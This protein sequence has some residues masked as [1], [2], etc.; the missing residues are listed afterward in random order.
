MSKTK[1]I[2]GKLRKREWGDRCLRIK[3]HKAHACTEGK[4]QPTER[5]KVLVPCFRIALLLPLL[6]KRCMSNISNC[7]GFTYSDFERVCYGNGVVT[8]VT[9]NTCTRVFSEK[10]KWMA[11]KEVYEILDHRIPH[12]E[13]LVGVSDSD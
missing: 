2:N 5:L 1:D 6:S 7:K 9:P 11:V 3:I 10:R 8:E 12:A 13:V 4:K